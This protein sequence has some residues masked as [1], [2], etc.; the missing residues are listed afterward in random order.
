MTQSELAKALG[1][2]Q[3]TV[4]KHLSG[5]SLPTGLVKKAYQEQFPEIYAQILFIYKERNAND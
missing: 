3:S 5:S 4:S 2:Q 1:V